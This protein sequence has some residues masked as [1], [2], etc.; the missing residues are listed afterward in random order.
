MFT[1]EQLNTWAGRPLTAGELSRLSEAVRQ[2][3]TD[4]V[5]ADITPAGERTWTFFG[6]WRNDTIV[7]EYE[8][9]GTVRDDRVD[10]GTHEQGLWAASGTGRTL[11]EA[12]RNALAEYL[13]LDDNAEQRCPNSR[14]SSR[15]GRFD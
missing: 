2:Y 1:R 10:T 9:P 4:M 3:I 11:D 5:S 14:D 12:R 7:V 15:I 6:H 8:E 13:D